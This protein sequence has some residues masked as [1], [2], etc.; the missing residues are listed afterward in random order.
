M[1]QTFSSTIRRKEMDAVLTC[2]VDEKIGPGELNA[3]LIQGVKEFFSCAGAVALRS[4]VFALKSA[5]KIFDLPK[6]SFIMISSLAPSWELFAI[7]ELG[8]KPLVL[9]VDSETAQLTE[10]I[11]EEGIKSGGRLLILYEGLGII[12]PQI[13]EIIS[14][15]IPVIE[16]VSKSAGAIL[17]NELQG[18]GEAQTVST[19]QE[20][21]TKKAGSF[22]LYTICALEEHDTITAGGG[23]ILFAPARREWSVLKS[24]VETIPSTEIL[25]D[26]NSALALVQFKEFARNE[27]IRKEIYAL[28]VRA[29]MQGKNKT[30]LRNL[31]CDIAYSFPIVLNSGF[32]DVKLYAQKKDIEITRAFDTSVISAREE[33]FGSSCKNARTLYLRTALFPLYP[34]LS[35][36]QIEKITKVLGTLP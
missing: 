29:V 16:D 8:Y 31:D 10:Q 25:P 13:E 2:M 19:P 6:D 18:D 15:G 22:G 5:L 26:I 35:K 32:K 24:L 28:Y 21:S 14:L 17:K 7:E 3:R 12:P 20:A 30:I 23:A 27:I 33:E 34:R 9:D 4:P 11:V 36:A 1:I